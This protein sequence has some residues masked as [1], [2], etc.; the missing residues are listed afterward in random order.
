MVGIQRTRQYQATGVINAQAIHDTKYATRSIPAGVIPST[1]NFF[2]AAPSADPTSDRY[3]QGNTLVSS[4]KIFTIF[5]IAAQVAAGAGAVM[6]DFESIINTCSLRIVTSQKEYGVFPLLMMPAGGGAAYQ[7]GQVA[8]TPAAVPGNLSVI[9]VLNG[10]PTQSATF[11]L[12]RAL[13][14]QANQSFYMEL[15]GPVAAGV[16]G[17]QTLT[18]AIRVRLILN[19]VEER[20]AA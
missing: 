9:G 18:G 8:V 11:A 13:E 15:L 10:M 17:A 12:A 14:I 6:A 1:V 5:S 16:W 2:G 7:S 3:E 19:G 4:G 20:A